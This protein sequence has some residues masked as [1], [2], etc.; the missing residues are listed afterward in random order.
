MSQPTQAE[1]EPDVLHA[2]AVRDL[3]EPAGYPVYLGENE[4]PDEPPFP[5]LVAWCVPG[6]PYGP[7]RM[8][9]HDGSVLTR[10]QIT[11]VAL[12]PL[13][14]VGAAARCRRLLH[15]KRPAIA[16]RRCGDMA[17]QPVA[18]AVPTVD[19]TV[20]G[21][22]GQNIYVAYLDFTLTSTLIRPEPE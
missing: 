16:G 17:Q 15:R 4:I 5:Y 19:P 20:R 8:A 18:Q 12:A 22:Q 13:D 21:P 14:V 11:V 10:H 9:G 1:I 3:L 7:E 2:Q 6:E